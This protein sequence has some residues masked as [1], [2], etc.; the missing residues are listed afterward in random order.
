MPELDSKQVKSLFD[1]VARSELLESDAI[2]DIDENRRVR[3]SEALRNTD[4]GFSILHADTMPF[5]Y[6]SNLSVTKSVIIDTKVEW[7]N[8]A[9]TELGFETDYEVRFLSADNMRIAQTRLALE[10]EYRSDSNVSEY[11]DSWGRDVGRL[12]ENMDYSGLGNSM[13]KVANYAGW[14]GLFRKLKEDGV[15]FLQGRYDFM[16]IEKIGQTTPSRY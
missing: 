14:I 13:E 12:R 11:Q 2:V 3:I 9:T 4:A 16:K 7:E 10:Y 5:E 8:I 6:V 15:P 1:F